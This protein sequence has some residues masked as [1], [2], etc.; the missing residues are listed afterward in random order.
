MITHWL[1][2]LTLHKILIWSFVLNKYIID[3]CDN[4]MVFL[5]LVYIVWRI[6]EMYF[7]NMYPA[8]VIATFNNC[9]PRNNEKHS[10][11]RMGKVI[12]KHEK[13]CMD[14]MFLFIYNIL[15]T[16]IKSIHIFVWKSVIINFIPCNPCWN[17]TFDHFLLRIPFTVGS[18]CLFIRIL[19]SNSFHKI[20][21]RW[22]ICNNIWH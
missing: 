16:F 14:N 17:I 4:N 5:H 10:F 22:R 6:E 20:V 7:I 2:T 8:N 1:I 18:R 15:Y 3:T 13:N 11:L 12:Y 21:T 19:F 9:K